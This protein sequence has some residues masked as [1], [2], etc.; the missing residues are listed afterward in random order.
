[1]RDDSENGSALIS[2]LKSGTGTAFVTVLLGGLL[3]QFISCG[4]QNR[5]KEREF[6][7]AWLKARADQALASRKEYLDARKRTFNE[8]IG[9]A[10]EMASASED[11]LYVTSPQYK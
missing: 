1:M 6:N 5:V 4:I 11:L 8:T 2:L 3:G 7:D 10:A 9:L